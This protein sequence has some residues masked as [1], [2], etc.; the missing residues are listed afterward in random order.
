MLVFV[1]DAPKARHPRTLRVASFAIDGGANAIL[2]RA[3]RTASVD[4]CVLDALRELTR[5]R[6]L[7][8]ASTRITNVRPTQVDGLHLP[9]GDAGPPAFPPGIV[10]TRS[11]HS[12]DAAVAAEHAGARAL[13]LGT[14]F[15]SPSHPGGPT[16]GLQGVRDV[17]AAVRTPV[18][19]IGA[20]SAGNAADVIDAGASGVAAISAIHDA[21]DAREA[22]RKIRRALDNAWRKRES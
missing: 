1:I 22:T 6:A 13:V 5:N 16:I 18:I 12:I 14:V 21:R 15:P 2:L 7:L 17:A 20:I 19:A 3:G 8:I 9:E 11:V 10:I 4:P